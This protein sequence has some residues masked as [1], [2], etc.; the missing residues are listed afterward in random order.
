LKILIT[1][2]KNNYKFIGYLISNNYFKNHSIFIEFI[3]SPNNIFYNIIS[4]FDFRYSSLKSN[5]FKSLELIDLLVINKD[6]KLRKNENEF[7]IIL[8]PYIRKDF[9]FKYFINHS[10]NYNIFLKYYKL[11]IQ[12]K[13]TVI[14][15]F[16][17]DSNF[18]HLTKNFP[19]V[20]GVNNSFE[21]SNFILM[22][23]IIS[24]LIEIES[25]F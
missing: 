19:I 20:R 25:A 24:L 3:D 9:K 5:K 15:D 21:L 14:S 16:L 12:N 11:S 1:I 17:V 22:D 7:D 18:K 23:Y 8:S 2:S 13:N 10:I 4:R 6:I